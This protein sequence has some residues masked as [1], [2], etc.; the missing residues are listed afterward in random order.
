MELKKEVRDYIKELV[1]DYYNEHQLQLHSVC[2]KLGLN[3][4]EADFNDPKISG[5]IFAKNG[6]HTIYINHK[7]STTRKRF[8]TA[9]EVGHYISALCGSY[10]K[11][12][13]SQDGF[14]DY[15]ISFRADNIQS[16]AETEANE[17][18]AEMLMPEKVVKEFI[19]YG[20][21]IEQMA[22]KFFVSPVAMTIRVERVLYK[23]GIYLL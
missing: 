23:S 8:T 11:D 7:H 14:K 6:V 2:E 1:S 5:M 19:E 3:Y 22:D 18:A 17:I 21:S 15:S 12:Q 10:S 13:L 20:L 16:N 9:H 4:I